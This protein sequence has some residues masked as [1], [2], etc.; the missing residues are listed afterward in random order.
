MTIKNKRKNQE[1]NKYGSIFKMNLS[2][3]YIN[4][5]KEFEEIVWFGSGLR[6]ESKQ[7]TISELIKEITNDIK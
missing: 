5:R 4:F 1:K 7:Q 3:D 2:Q 6:L